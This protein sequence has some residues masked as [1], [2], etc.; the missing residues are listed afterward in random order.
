MGRMVDLHNYVNVLYIGFLLTN[1]VQCKISNYFL[2]FY[3]ELRLEA[4]SEQ[5]IITSKNNVLSFIVIINNSIRAF[6]NNSF[7][8]RFVQITFC[9]KLRLKNKLFIYNFLIKCKYK[10]LTNNK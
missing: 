1:E 4:A 7:K 5:I 8:F 3:K 10:N 2:L 6:L 9:I